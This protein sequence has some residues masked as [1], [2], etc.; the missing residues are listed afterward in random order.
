MVLLSARKF[1]QKL[2]LNIQLKAH[3]Y[4]ILSMPRYAM[5]T[6]LNK[7]EID[8][9]EKVC[10]IKRCSK[11]KLLRD[12]VLEYCEACIEG[13]QQDA[14]EKDG[15]GTEERGQRTTKVSY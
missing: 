11:Y 13:E 7:K 5:T 8:K 1:P 2:M 4:Y 3:I 10:E 6:F 12:A 15:S 14:G 9:V